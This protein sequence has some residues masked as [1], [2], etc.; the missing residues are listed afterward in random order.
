M[1]PNH[2][3]ADLIAN[4]PKQKMVGKSMEINAA[5]AMLADGVTL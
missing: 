4:F 3:D 1:M 5:D 2:K